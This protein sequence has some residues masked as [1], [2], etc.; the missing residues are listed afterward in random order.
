MPSS[1]EEKL[2]LLKGTINI[3]NIKAYFI[4]FDFVA[5]DFFVAV[6]PLLVANMY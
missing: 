6:K 4:L 3:K 1:F 5:A 2:L